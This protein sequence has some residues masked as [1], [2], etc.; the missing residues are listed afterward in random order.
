MSKHARGRLDQ[1]LAVAPVLKVG[2]DIFIV[3]LLH[4]VQLNVAKTAWMYTF[5]DK[6]KPQRKGRERAT[7][8]MGSIGCYLD[9]PAKGQQNPENKFMTNGATVDDY[10]M[11][12]LRDPKSKSPGLA[13]NTSKTSK[14][15]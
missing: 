15:Y 14:P 7:A 6:L 10:V 3:D 4:C 2:T 5:A 13:A 1:M 8:Y 11:G 12:R 9:L